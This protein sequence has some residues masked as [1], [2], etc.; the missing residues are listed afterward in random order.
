MENEP[1]G[2]NPEGGAPSDETTAKLT[3]ALAEN[4]A[5]KKTQSS[6]QRELERVRQSGGS[7]K[8]LE[9]RIQ[10]N[11]D[12]QIAVLEAVGQIA[13]AGEL[14]DVAAKI[15]TVVEQVRKNRA[16]PAPELK[17]DPAV[18]AG[19]EIVSAADA[20]GISE[21]KFED[22]WKTDPRLVEA[23]ALW[24]AGSYDAAIVSFKTALTKS[25]AKMLPEDEIKKRVDEELAK[26]RRSAAP[27]SAPGS[28]TVGSDRTIKASELAKLPA[29]ERAKLAKD[30]RKALKG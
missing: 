17:E 25:P 24:R 16:A 21:D 15:T 22:V 4:E 1:T 5:L 6:I 30:L 18:K 29:D 10:A 12:A 11:E 26:A 20:A 9:A 13:A 19:A 23:R 7:I 3:A 27:T 2:A 28:T 8:G 14:K